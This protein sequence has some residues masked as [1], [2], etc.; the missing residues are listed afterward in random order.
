VLL[1]RRV[2]AFVAGLGLFAICAGVSVVTLKTALIGHPLLRY[3]ALSILP[4]MIW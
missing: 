3:P 2:V 1:R 4:A